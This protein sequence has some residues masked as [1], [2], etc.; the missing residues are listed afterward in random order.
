MHGALLLPE[1]LGVCA[2]CCISLTVRLALQ[3][4]WR[5]CRNC[6]GLPGNK[7]GSAMRL[8]MKFTIPV[9]RGKHRL[10]IP[11]QP[12]LIGLLEKD[13]TGAFA[14][15][16]GKISSFRICRFNEAEGLTVFGVCVMIASRR[17]PE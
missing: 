4:T 13:V 14:V 3:R 8:M 10:I 5:S 16:H 2:V 17:T 7:G 1:L 15:D 11:G 6:W 9:E 12:C